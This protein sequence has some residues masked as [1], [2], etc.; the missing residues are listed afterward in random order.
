MVLVAASLALTAAAQAQGFTSL[1][2]PSISTGAYGYPIREAARVALTTVRDFLLDRGAPAEVTFCLFSDA[3][4][5][6]YR[7]ALAELKGDES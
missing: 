3:D 1:A 7:E 2:F 5:A 6:V 4:L